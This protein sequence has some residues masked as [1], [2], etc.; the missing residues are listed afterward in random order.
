[1]RGGGPWRVLLTA[2]RIPDADAPYELAVLQIL[3]PQDVTSEL[4]GGLHDHGVP[5]AGRRLFVNANRP[6]NVTGSGC[7]DRPGGEFARALRSSVRRQRVG[8]VPRQGQ[9]EEYPCGRP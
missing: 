3:G 6:E 7:T 9:D 4:G 5:E 8:H 2:E 1:M